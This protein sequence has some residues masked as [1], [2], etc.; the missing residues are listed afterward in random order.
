MAFAGFFKGHISLN[1]KE[2]LVFNIEKVVDK[3]VEAYEMGASESLSE[4]S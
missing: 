2:K 4:S 1:L 3:V